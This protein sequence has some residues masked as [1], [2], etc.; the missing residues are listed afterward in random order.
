MIRIVRHAMRGVICKSPNEYGIP[1]VISRGG[2]RVQ[3]VGKR[4][5]TDVL[6]DGMLHANLA[7]VRILNPGGA[8]TALIVKD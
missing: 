5:I 3:T 1:V 6:V 8:H 4:V 7:T 2:R